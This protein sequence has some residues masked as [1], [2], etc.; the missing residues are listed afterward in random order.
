MRDK[1]SLFKIPDNSW[2]VKDENITSQ[3]ASVKKKSSR[4]MCNIF[5]ETKNDNSDR[6]NFTE[7]SEVKFNWDTYSSSSDTKVSINDK[8]TPNVSISLFR[9]I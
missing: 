2:D 9:F 3:L 5:S 1:Q 8:N 6:I 7:N 4:T